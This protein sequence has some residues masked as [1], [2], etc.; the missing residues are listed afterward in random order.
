VPEID[1]GISGYVSRNNIEGLIINTKEYY[2]IW[3]G[4]MES[5][6]IIINNMYILVKSKKRPPMFACM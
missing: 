5:V 3:R 6:V 1:P 2:D 4:D